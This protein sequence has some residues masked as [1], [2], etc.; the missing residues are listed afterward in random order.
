MISL[1]KPEFREEN[2]EFTTYLK[3]TYKKKKTD[4]VFFFYL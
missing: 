2:R 1:K 4:K 3:E